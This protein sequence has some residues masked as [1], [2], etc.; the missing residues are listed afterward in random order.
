MHYT[1]HQLNTFTQ[2]GFTAAFGAL[3]EGSPWIAHETWQQRPFADAAALHA[4]LVA[5]VQHA[6][7]AQQVALIQAHPD[8]AGK[9][10]LAGALTAESRSEQA[11]VG[12]DQLTAAEFADFNQLNAAYRQQFGF[13]FVICVREQTTTSILANFR[14]RLTHNRQQE[15]ATALAEIG[16]IAG[17]RLNDILVD[18]ER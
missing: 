11:S 1:I 2:A 10:A 15:I 4:A 16:N 5:T 9:A 13:P 8:L 7:E 14:V 3:F 18:G 17:L 6:T 12:L